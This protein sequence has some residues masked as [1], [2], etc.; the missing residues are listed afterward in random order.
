MLKTE[1]LSVLLKVA[2]VAGTLRHGG[3]NSLS[4]GSC[5]GWC[6]GEPS[7]YGVVNRYPIIVAR[8][9]GDL[10]P[11]HCKGVAKRYPLQGE[12]LPGMV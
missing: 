9:G 2:S 6:G 1:F 4:G 10:P 5:R 12:K 11:P 8:G 7:C 3:E